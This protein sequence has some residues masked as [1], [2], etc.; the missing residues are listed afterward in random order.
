MEIRKLI[1]FT[2]EEKQ[3]LGSFG[4]ISKHKYAV[5]KKET[6]DST[7]I[8]MKLIDLDQPYV[9]QEL[10]GEE[11][12]EHSRKIV[13]LG[14]SYGLYVD[15]K[16]AAAAIAEPQYWNNTLLIWQFQVASEHQGK[17]YGRQLMAQLVE[18]AKAGGFRALSLETQNTNVPAILFYKSCG[19]EIDGLNLSFY[20]NHD[21]EDGEVAIF[22]KKKL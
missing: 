5:R 6:S 10:N 15:H 17:S 22:M 21:V 1:E 16:L 13:E 3:L 20:T 11:D 7:T 12:D 18:A 2:N 9:K 4:Y 14:H 8:T 19:F